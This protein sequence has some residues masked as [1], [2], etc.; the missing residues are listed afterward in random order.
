[1][2]FNNNE[3]YIKVAKNKEEIKVGAGLTVQCLIF[4][5]V[6]RREEFLEAVAREQKHFGEEVAIEKQAQSGR[7]HEDECKLLLY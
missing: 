4:S 6:E 1:M 3:I 5:Y 2:L 7:L